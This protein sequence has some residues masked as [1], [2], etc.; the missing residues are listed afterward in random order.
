MSKNLVVKQMNGVR[1]VERVDVVATECVRLTRVVQTHSP[2]LGLL[3][4]ETYN[5]TLSCKGVLA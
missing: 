5:G 2:A 1:P 4:Y 3:I